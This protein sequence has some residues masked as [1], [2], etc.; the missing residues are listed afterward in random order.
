MGTDEGHS[1]PGEQTIFRV[2]VLASGS[3]SN[4][5]AII[6]QL[7]RPRF[8][9]MDADD[10][11][12][13]PLAAGGAG[14]GPRIEV[15]L[16]ISDMPNARA[17]DRAMR[18]GIRTA[19]LPIADY[20]DREQHDLAMVTKLLEVEPDLV[21]LAGYMR[22][23]APAL[24]KAFPWRVINLHPALLP[25]FPGTHSIA[26]A[27]RYGVK[28]TGVTVHFVDPGVDTGPVIA[29]EAV[30]I[31]NNDTVESLAARIHAVEHRML[32]E[33]VRLFAEGRV[34]P[35]LPGSR[36]VQVD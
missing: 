13:A 26:D 28:V 17:L 24:L 33:V 23:V 11:E 12:V 30:R 22:I 5:Q 7:H 29:Q 14:E 1:A 27:V 20:R 36:V 16:V 21:V 15:V 9:L 8:Q 6:D 19:V 31:E 34:T 18:A 35:P 32:P 3:G 25:A 10:Y 2:A 4:L